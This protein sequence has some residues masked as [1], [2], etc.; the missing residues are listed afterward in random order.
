MAFKDTTVLRLAI[1][2]I[3][4]F[5]SFVCSSQCTVENYDT[6]AETNL[7]ISLSSEFGTYG[8][9][10]TV[11]CN[12]NLKY[13]DIFQSVV[14]DVSTARIDIYD[15]IDINVPPI[16]TQNY[17]QINSPPDA[18]PIRFTM[19]E[20]VLLLVGHTYTILVTASNVGFQISNGD[21]YSGGSA[22]IDGVFQPDSDL[23]FSL[24]LADP[25]NDC[26]IGNEYIMPNAILAHMLH[27]LK[28]YP[29]T[30]TENGTLTGLG[31]TGRSYINIRMALYDDLNGAPN[32]LL[33]ETGVTPLNYGIQTIPVTPVNL[34]AGNYWI[35]LLSGSLGNYF[36]FVESYD[37]INPNEHFIFLSNFQSPMPQPFGGQPTTG[38][39][40]VPVFAKISCN[41]LSL[42]DFE[43]RSIQAYPN[44]TNDK[45]YLKGI[46]EKTIYS[47]YTS[48]GR[49]I[50]SDELMPGS[51]IDV[52]SFASGIYLIKFSNRTTLKFVKT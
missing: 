38:F 28:A 10:F 30:L 12:G 42:N 13:F 6:G 11:A 50:V 29:V 45:L 4:V 9:S 48:T 25:N 24:F 35:A 46:T 22:I 1:S 23:Y 17:D 49:K 26:N 33:A 36:T 7:E 37:Y 31:I 44:P 52:S 18:L 2:L 20:D 39:G 40:K 5:T 14:W 3:C 16:Y 32:N 27:S 51:F 15:G 8:Q 19:A 43:I 47:I 34:T 41:V 21:T